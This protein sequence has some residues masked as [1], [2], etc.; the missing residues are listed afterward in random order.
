[1]ETSLPIMPPG[2][3]R[4]KVVKCSKLTTSKRDMTVYC[5]IVCASQDMQTGS[6]TG[7]EG[8]DVAFFW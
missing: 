5:T 2:L 6:F 1:M 7:K 3:H 4:L 8:K